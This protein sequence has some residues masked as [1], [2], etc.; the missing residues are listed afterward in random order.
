MLKGPEDMVSWSQKACQHKLAYPYDLFPQSPL[1]ACHFD[2]P[3]FAVGI[4]SLLLF[5]FRPLKYVRSQ[6]LC[7]S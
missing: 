7:I 6:F 4:I 2:F 3:S 1:Q 5:H